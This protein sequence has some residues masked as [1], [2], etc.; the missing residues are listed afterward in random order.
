[1]DSPYFLVNVGSTKKEHFAKISPQDA[2]LALLY[3]WRI[4]DTKAQMDRHKIYYVS[5]KERGRSGRYVKLHRL[6]M[7]AQDGTHVDHINGDGL[8]NRREN[9]RLVTPQ[10]NQANSRKHVIGKSRFKGVS[11]SKPANKWRAYI[12]RD[13][14]QIHIG[15]Y[16]D[17]FEAAR[18]Y[19]AKAAEM[20][21]DHAHLNLS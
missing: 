17:E 8:D 9:L 15:L 1:M 21:G 16:A 14:R 4:V 2:Q 18:A 20:W 13:R 5:A 12:V 10:L 7:N 3:R 6:I 19:D 11:W